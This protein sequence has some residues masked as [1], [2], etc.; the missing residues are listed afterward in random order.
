MLIHDGRALLIDFGLS[1]VMEE[2]SWYTTSHRQGGN[3][4]WIAPELTMN[5]D[6]ER[7]PA[8]DVYS[9]GCLAMEVSSAT[10]HKVSLLI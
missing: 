6:A 7:T 4:R 10:L 5:E 8:S 3:L 2:V 1:V 9:F